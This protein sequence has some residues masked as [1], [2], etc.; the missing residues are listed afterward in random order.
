MAQD[1]ARYQ[2]ARKALAE[3]RRVDEAKDI[4]DKALAMQVYARQAKDH[5]L[6]DHATDIR[7]RAEIRAGEL[8]RE[9]K[10]KGERNEGG[11]QNLRPGSHAATPGKQPKLSDL[12]VSKTQSSRWQKLAALP[13]PEQETFIESAKKGAHDSIE[14]APKRKSNGAAK[15]VQPSAILTTVERQALKAKRRILDLLRSLT[16]AEKSEFIEILRMQLDELTK[17]KVGGRAP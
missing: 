6:I 17:S 5:E 4:R 1:L 15:S 10:Q 9:M 2:A 11:K 14:S 12:G 8:L 3:A 13:K 16:A 7:M